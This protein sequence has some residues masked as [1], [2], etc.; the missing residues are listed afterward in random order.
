MD[1]ANFVEFQE[2]WQICTNC[3]QPF[4]N[5][6][7]IDLA[8]SFISFTEEAHDH[9]GNSKWDKMNI[10]IAHQLKICAMGN[11]NK[12]QKMEKVRII[13]KLF[14]LL[15][16]AQTKQDIKM[17]SWIHMPKDSD[18]YEYYSILSGDCEAFA[19]NKGPCNL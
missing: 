18:E 11:S 8:S 19:Y 10:M 13:N 6:L 4:Q 2:P 17:K 7:S 16:V 15:M 3:K 14:L 9:A 1:E 12:I 5:Q